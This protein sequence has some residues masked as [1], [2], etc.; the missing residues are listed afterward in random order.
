MGAPFGPK[1]SHNFPRT[2][3]PSSVPFGC[4]PGIGRGR[5]PSVAA[6]D[7]SMHRV[8]LSSSR[9][10]GRG[11]GRRPRKEP[12]PSTKCFECIID[13]LPRLGAP[14]TSKQLGDRKG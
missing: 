5:V 7:P 10:V 1:A 2:S 13:E 8:W 14:S 6:S 11:G 9:A 12:L 4:M 3:L